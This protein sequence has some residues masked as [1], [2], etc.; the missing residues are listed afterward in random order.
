M[1][2]N[3][4]MGLLINIKNQKTIIIKEG[5][6]SVSLEDLEIIWTNIMRLFQDREQEIISNVWWKLEEN[7]L[8]INFG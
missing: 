2:P 3:F 8:N 6:A 4:K 5:G 7:E 1:V